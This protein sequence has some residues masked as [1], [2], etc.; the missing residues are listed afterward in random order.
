MNVAVRY[1]AQLRQAAGRSTE[2]VAVD[3][4]CTVAGLV[5]ALAGRTPALRPVLLDSAG[6]PRRGLLVF[7]GDR[8]ASGDERL[9]DGVEV[10]LMTPIAGGGQ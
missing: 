8:Q 4:G 2:T 1:L 6:A 9:T 5:A 10:T 3:A 7:V